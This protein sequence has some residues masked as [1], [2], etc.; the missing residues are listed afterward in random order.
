M[1]AKCE[2]TLGGYAI[3]HSFEPL[4]L[5]CHEPLEP[6]ADV[7]FGDVDVI[8]FC[9]SGRAVPHQFSQCMPIHAALGAPGSESVA[10]TV[11]R[12]GVQAGFADRPP[13]GLLYAD[14]VA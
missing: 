7:R 13:V 1:T 11:E 4:G 9:D 10:P 3:L 2:R 14:Q 12:E 6:G 5:I 8:L